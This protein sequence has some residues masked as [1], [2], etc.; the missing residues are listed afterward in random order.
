MNWREI[1]YSL[2]QRSAVKISKQNLS[3]KGW[4]RGWAGQKEMER[5]K[6]CCPPGSLESL[7]TM[8]TKA[9]LVSGS[10]VEVITLLQWG[11]CRKTKWEFLS[12]NC[13]IQSVT[14]GHFKRREGRFFK[15]LN[16]IF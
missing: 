5:S 4:A 12:S 1:V 8:G 6:M 14:L 11:W 15:C 2:Q 16:I 7:A 10:D 9:R 13:E 3:V